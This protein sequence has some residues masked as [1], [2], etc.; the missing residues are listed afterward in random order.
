LDK[1]ADILISVRPEKFTFQKC[2]GN[3]LKGKIVTRTYMGNFIDYHIDINGKI[4]RVQST[5]EMFFEEGAEVF[6]YFRE[7]NCTVVENKDVSTR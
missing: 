3:K 7:E 6:V 4:M 1:G 2:E 5:G